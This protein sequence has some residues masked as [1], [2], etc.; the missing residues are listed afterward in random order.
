[1]HTNKW[2][3]NVILIS[4]VAL[5]V[6]FVIGLQVPLRRI[7]IAVNELITELS[8]E[9]TELMLQMPSLAETNSELDAY[10]LIKKYKGGLVL[11]SLISSSTT[12]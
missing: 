1:M 11:S 2:L 7:D 9:H 6:Q 3:K 4:I 12:A 10:D 8:L 5:L